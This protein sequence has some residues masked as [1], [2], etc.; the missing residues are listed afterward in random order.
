[1]AP[2]FFVVLAGVVGGLA[3]AYVF[4]KMKRSRNE[5]E[6][7]DVFPAGT[8][9]TD[10][11]NMAHIK[12]AGVGGLGLVVVALAVALDVPEIGQSQAISAVLGI[13]FAVGL[14]F[15][16]RR[17]GPMPS[18]GGQMGANTMLSIDNPEP[19]PTAERRPPQIKNTITTAPLER[20]DRRFAAK[21]G[22]A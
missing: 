10:V 15:W 13:L 12:V 5:P 4:S 2:I 19:R 14:I 8:G 7:S 9:S 1:M 6:L 18:S 17:R 22:S 21:L 20:G 3:F 16:R 11:I